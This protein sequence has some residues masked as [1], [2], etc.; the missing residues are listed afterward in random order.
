[1]LPVVIDGSTRGIRDGSFYG[2]IPWL[3][4]AM[5]FSL[6]PT[7]EGNALEG[8]HVVEV[9]PA[10]FDGDDCD[11]IVAGY[12]GASTSL[13]GYRLIS[14][15]PNRWDRFVIDNGGIAAQCCVA[16]DVNNDGQIDLVAAG[17][18]T[19][20]VKLYVNETRGR[21]SHDDLRP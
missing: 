2:P 14:G 4:A 19:H 16:A 13:Y 1:L 6:V 12:R 3:S 18:S 11:E 20:N 17:G 15:W 9:R 10:D 7:Y 8:F 21:P 5:R